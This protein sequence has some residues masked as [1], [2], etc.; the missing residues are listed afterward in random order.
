MSKS[1]QK[2]NSWFEHRL[3]VGPYPSPALKDWHV[4]DF[5]YIINVSGTYHHGEAP[6]YKGVNYFWFPMSEQQFDMGV[7]SLFGA[8]D[9][10]WHA[11]KENAYVYLHCHSGKNRSRTV[12]AAYHYLRTGTHMMQEK[13]GTYL[14]KLLQNCGRHYLPAQAEME[15]WLSALRKALNDS[16]VDS[17]TLR[18]SKLDY[19]NN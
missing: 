7:N 10:L 8:L 6:M 13:S 1:N 19:I 14:N 11:E 15:G 3:I 18:Q 16:L 5:Q 4:K 17:A 12:Q 9:V 2:F